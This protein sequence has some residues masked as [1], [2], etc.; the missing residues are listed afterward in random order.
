MGVWPLQSPV[1]PCDFRHNG[2]LFLG[3]RHPGKCTKEAKGSAKCFQETLRERC[4][5]LQSNAPNDKQHRVDVYSLGEMG[6]GACRYAPNG[7]THPINCV[8]QSQSV[9]TLMDFS[10]LL[11]RMRELR[12]HLLPRTFNPVGAYAPRWH[13]RAAGYRVLAHAE[14][15]A[16]IELMVAGALERCV[17]SAKTNAVRLSTAWLF[18][19]YNQTEHFKN[20]E[21]TIFKSAQQYPIIIVDT[22]N[23]ANHIEEIAKEFNTKVIKQN[24]GIREANILRLLIPIGVPLGLIESAVQ[25]SW[26]PKIDEF[27]QE[28]GKTAHQS[29]VNNLVDPKTEYETVQVIL[30]GIKLIYAEIMAMEFYSLYPIERS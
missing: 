25:G 13:D 24:S 10:G 9:L 18:T 26:L 15:Q 8:R 14:I 2:L 30:K 20:L 12:N 21:K 1:Q 4:R 22:D 5:F 16:F 19:Y 23:F 3:R 27:G 17:E 11:V 6:E 28:R 7:D 29:G